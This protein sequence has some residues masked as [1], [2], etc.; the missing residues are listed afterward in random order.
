MQP[1]YAK[2]GFA[3]HHR[4]TRMVEIGTQSKI[5]LRL[6]EPSSLPF[7]TVSAFDKVHFGHSRERFL[8]HWFTPAEGLGLQDA[9]G[10]LSGNGCHPP[11]PEAAS[12]SAHFSPKTPQAPKQSLTLFAPMPQVSRS[13]STHLKITQPQSNLPAEKGSA[14]SSAAHACTLATHPR[15]PIA[16]FTG[17]RH[18]S[19]AELDIRIQ[20]D[21]KEPHLKERTVFASNP[22]FQINTA[23]S[24]YRWLPDD[25][26]TQRTRKTKGRSFINSVPAKSN[27]RVQKTAMQYSGGTATTAAVDNKA[28]RDSTKKHCYFSGLGH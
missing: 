12:R 1:F 24:R 27:I 3:F 6:A 26:I 10:Q 5:K 11:L 21:P 15:Y 18:L 4:S 25:F 16:A 17:S 9:S 14:R 8:K 28:A 7:D 13:S 23:I 2:G 19:L 20:S 22:V